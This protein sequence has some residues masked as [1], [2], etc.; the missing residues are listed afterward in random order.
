VSRIRR[1]QILIAAGAL[2]AAPRAW[3]QVGGKPRRIAYVLTTSPLAETAGP[4]PVHPFWRVFLHELRVRGWIEGKNLV[5]ERRSAEGRFERAPEIFSEVAK[6]GA[7]VI[8]TQGPEFVRAAMKAAPAVPIVMVSRSPVEEGLVT[9]LSRPGGNV[10]GVSVEVGPEFHG[11]LLELLKEMFPK[12]RIVALLTLPSTGSRAA[13]AIHNAALALGLELFDAEW[14]QNSFETAFK[15]IESKRPDAL[16]VQRGSEHFARRAEIVGFARKMR[17]PDFH[18]YRE[19]VEV[20]GLCSYGA[21]TS[22]LFRKMAGYVDRILKGEK[23]GD[24]PIEQASKFELAINLRTA[25]TLGLKIPQSVLLRT[26]RL[27][28]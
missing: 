24:L 15:L 5:I 27:I 22:D 21:D 8:I 10:T 6:G 18:T 19:A 23:P 26:D 12:A 25:K 17:L 20:G 3:S 28:E 9:N 14:R 7:E 4:D 13:T 16:L 2:L 1:R 11:K